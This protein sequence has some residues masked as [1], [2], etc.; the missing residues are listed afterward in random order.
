[1]ENKNWPDHKTIEGAWKIACDFA[2]A[3]AKNANSLFSF[4][5]TLPYKKD[6]IVLALLNLLTSDDFRALMHKKDGGNRVLEELTSLLFRIA[7][8]YVPNEMEYK[9]IIELKNLSN[10][11]TNCDSLENLLREKF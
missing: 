2:D 7:I 11:I 1:M 8:I 9:K 4:N 6:T 3:E 10:K 5:E